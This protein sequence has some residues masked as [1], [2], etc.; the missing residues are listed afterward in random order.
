MGLCPVPSCNVCN[1]VFVDKDQLSEHHHLVHRKRKAPTV[2]STGS[3]TAKRV[4]KYYC[5]VCLVPFM[6]RE[7]LF[8]HKLSHLEDQTV[9]RSVEPHWDFQDPEV[10][11]LLQSNKDFIFA[12]HRLTDLVAD[13]NFPVTLRIGHD[14]WVSELSHLMECVADMNTEEA[15]KV[16][17]SCGFV[18]V[19]R[20]TGE[21]RYFVPHGNN[22][23]FKKP[24][25][26]DRPSSWRK[27]YDKMTDEAILT[28][29]TNHREDTK[30]IP[31][32]LTNVVVHLYYLGV[33]MA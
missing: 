24:V 18:L 23:F 7:E 14:R 2:S 16:N 22:A 33:T 5:R 27:I 9:W 1:E 17:F 4:A 3:K 10:N 32:M 11:R 29:V 20:E 8:H 6:T 25:S 13:Y 21:F 15:F 28:Y 31:L 19:H 26:I 30:W 12:P